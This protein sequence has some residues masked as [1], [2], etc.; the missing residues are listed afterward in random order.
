MITSVNI[1]QLSLRKCLENTSEFKGR[2]GLSELPRFCEALTGTHQGELCYQFYF[3]KDEE[4]VYFVEGF[5]ECCVSLTCERCLQAFLMPVF[6]QFKLAF[7]YSDEQAKQLPKVYEPV[8][9]QGD[10]LNAYDFLE[11]ELILSLPMHPKHPEELCSGIQTTDAL[12]ANGPYESDVHGSG[13][14]NS[15]FNVLSQLKK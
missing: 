10:D 3:G 7:V 4:G 5:C 9:V 12:D 13:E 8:F 11:D 2:V 6:A 15:P 1:S 14:R